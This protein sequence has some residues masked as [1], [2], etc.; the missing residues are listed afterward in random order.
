MA[1]RPAHAAA[2]TLLGV[3]IALAGC[4]SSQ[5][6]APPGAPPGRMSMNAYF[7]RYEAY[8]DLPD[9]LRSFIEEHA[10]LWKEPPKDLAEIRELQK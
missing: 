6:S 3:A 2:L 9:T 8:G 10:P 1:S 7:H 5:G 4:A